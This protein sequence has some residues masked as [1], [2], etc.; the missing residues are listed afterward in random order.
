VPI[1]S[2]ATVQAPDQAGNV[3]I[4]GTGGMYDASRDGMR[5]ITS[6]TLLAA[7]PTRWLTQ[8]CDERY[9]CAGVVIDRANGH[10]RSLSTPLDAYQP[11]SG[12]VSP[13]GRTAVLLHPNGRGANNLHLVDLATGA[14]RLT[15]ATTSSDLAGGSQALAW[16]P[17]SRWLFVTDGNGRLLALDR[18]GRVTE[19]E[20]PVGP[21]DQIALRTAP[22]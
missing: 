4:S 20:V 21:L 13:D 5:R 17:D 19:F 8:E 15:G 22:R 2:D 3:L 9:R 18:T 1:P 10:R 12:A 16:S 11:V 7:G 6:G 14:V